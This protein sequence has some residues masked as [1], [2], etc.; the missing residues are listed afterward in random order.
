MRAILLASLAALAGQPADPTVGMSGT[1]ICD[2]VGNWG[3]NAE[4]GCVDGGVRRRSAPRYTLT[5]NFDTRRIRLNGLDGHL[6]TD[7]SETEYWVYWNVGG[8][9]HPKL[10]VRRDERFLSLGLRLASE[11]GGSSVGEFR[12]RPER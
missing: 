5:V 7:R 1:Y 2:Y 8:M 6:E 9:G 10:T 12:C 3:C 4:G 11:S